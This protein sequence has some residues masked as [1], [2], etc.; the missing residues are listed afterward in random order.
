[1]R[2]SLGLSVLL[3]FGFSAVGAARAGVI[4]VDPGGGPGQALLQAAIDSAVDG[5]V[6]VIKAGD[7]DSLDVPITIDSKA[8]TIAADTPFMQ[9]VRGL[10][11]SRV[12]AGRTVALERLYL[13]EH[14][15][16]SADNFTSGLIADLS[17]G[18]ALH[19]QDCW[20]TGSNG[21]L[22]VPTATDFPAY[23]AAVISGDGAA[24]FL[25]CR[26]LGGDGHHHQLD[27]VLEHHWPQP[28]AP[29]LVADEAR[30]ALYSCPLFGGDGGSGPDAGSD[31]LPDGA[32]ALVVRNDAFVL[33]YGGSCTGGA[34]GGNPE[35]GC[36]SGDGVTVEA[37]GGQ[38]WVRGATLVPGSVQAP[39]TS[40]EPVGLLGG[41]ATTFTEPAQAFFDGDEPVYREGDPML[42]LAIG[43]PG[44]AV[45]LL[46]SVQG[47]FVPLSIPRA[48]SASRRRC[49][50]GRS[51]SVSSTRAA[52]SRC[53]RLRPT[54]QRASTA[55][56]SSRRPSR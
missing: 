6:I 42:L 54:C 27:A 34:E 21:F 18:G 3:A 56:S 46:A 52:R 49:S 29:A 55:C 13:G 45:L 31:P 36:T 15:G 23:P 39:G 19:V 50:S 1:M 33:A 2:A 7:Y 48:C 35:P 10:S 8:I 47:G 14:D 28:G 24:T 51:R 26:L 44:D 11:V 17:G 43:H 9:L 16:L 20:V 40:G 25:N 53:R 4:V 5:D 30:V 38:L 12:P 37:S 41:S 22:D 32:S